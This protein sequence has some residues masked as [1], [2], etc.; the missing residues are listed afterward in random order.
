MHCKLHRSITEILSFLAFRPKLSVK[1]SC[2]W[3]VE[4]VVRL[5]W[6]TAS[7]TNNSGFKIEKS[8]DSEVFSEIGFVE[9]KGTT[10]TPQQYI[11]EDDKVR[12]GTLYY[13]LKQID[14]DGSFDYSDM[15]L[16]QISFPENFS[17][18]QNY[19]NPFNPETKIQ[20]ELPAH[21]QVKILIYN[22]KGRQ[23]LT[24]FEGEQGAGRRHVIWNG[25]NGEGVEVAS[26]VY[27]V[28][29]ETS[30][31]VLVKKMVLAR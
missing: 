9:G 31:F 18:G 2:S 29:M 12:N 8:F 17:L 24:L 25:R 10:T 16:V 30:E 1:D 3:V 15:I 4:N 27:L 23:I 14:T 28:R 7:E 5:F 6:G 13:R 21:S 22:L 20:Y 19:P 11:F 26:G